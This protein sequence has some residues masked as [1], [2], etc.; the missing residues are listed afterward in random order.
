MS[1]NNISWTSSAY[2]E[3]ENYE[4]RLNTY[5]ERL[6]PILIRQNG[7]TMVKAGFFYRGLGYIV[8]CAFC[9]VFYTN[10]YEMMMQ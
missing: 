4:Q 1:T 10:G 5:F 6:W 2:P 7:M 9:G 3:Y 8:T